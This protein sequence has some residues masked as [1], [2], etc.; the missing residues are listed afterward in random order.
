MTIKKMLPVLMTVLILS[1]CGGVDLTA[2]SSPSEKSENVISDEELSENELYEKELSEFTALFNTREYIGFLARSFTSVDEMYWGYILEY[3]AGIATTVEDEKELNDYK[4]YKGYNEIEQPL[5]KIKKADLENYVKTHVEGAQPPSDLGIYETYFE[6]YDAYY[7]TWYPEIN[8]TYTCISSEKENDLYTLRFSVKDNKSKQ[9]NDR[10]LKLTKSG[11]NYIIK[12]NEILDSSHRENKPLT[13]NL[14]QHDEPV[15]INL[16]YDTIDEYSDDSGYGT[17]I[18]KGAR[19][20][21]IIPLKLNVLETDSF[22]YNGDSSDDIA[23]VADTDTGKRLFVF[24]GDDYYL[25]L[26]ADE[27]KM[28]E[29]GGDFSID[30]IRKTVQC[31]NDDFEEGDYRKAYAEFALSDYLESA[32]KKDYPNCSFGL[33]CIDDDDIP[34]LLSDHSGYFIN[35]YRYDDNQVKELFTGPYGTSGCE[36]YSYAPKKGLIY[37]RSTG[38]AGLNFYNSY[39]S[40]QDNGEFGSDCYAKY[41][42]YDDLDGDGEPSEEEEELAMSDSWT[43]EG[44]VEYIDCNDENMPEEKVKEKIEL[45]E[46]YDFYG[47]DGGMSYEELIEELRKQ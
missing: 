11:D 22:D 31:P 17:I 39:E 21:A 44:K 27:A 29:L 36:G 24:D 37:S 20:M 35:L 19:T 5:Y 34:E 23:I 42:N 32:D 43:G 3:G 1:G 33:F 38:Y 46:T 10:I 30:S 47:L 6:D 26:D 40:I 2:D 9:Y 16:Y 28:A 45:Y 18:K 7:F 15:Q 4:N 14:S 12:S 41:Y 13:F 8:R 25:M